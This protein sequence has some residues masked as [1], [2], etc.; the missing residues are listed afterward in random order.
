MD[1]T[2]QVP[3]QYCSLHHQLLFLLPVKS[4]TGFCFCFDLSQEQN[5][6]VT[7]YTVDIH[8]K[9]AKSHHLSAWFLYLQKQ[10]VKLVIVQVSP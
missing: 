10:E 5:A 1:L 4:T 8:V 7:Q 9:V 6:G 2:F 3:M